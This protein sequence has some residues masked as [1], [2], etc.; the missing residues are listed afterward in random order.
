MLERQLADLLSAIQMLVSGNLPPMLV[1]REMLL[2]LLETIQE[3]LDR[4]HSQYQVI[5]KDISWYYRRATYVYLRTESELII[6]L[7]IPL[8][9]FRNP[10]FVYA[11]KTYPMVLPEEQNNVMRLDDIAFGIAVDQSSKFYYTLTETE[12]LDIG[13]HHHSLTKKI[14]TEFDNTSCIMNIYLDKRE[15]IDKFCKYSIHVNS[16][17]SEIYHIQDA[18]IFLFNIPHY[19]LVCQNGSF[20]IPGCTACLVQLKPHCIFR[21]KS[22]YIPASMNSTNS[23]LESTRHILNSPLIM[24]FFQQQS[25][26]FLTGNT[27]FDSPPKVIIPKFEYFNQSLSK[28]FAADD[29]IKLDL[30]KAVDAVKRDQIIVQSLSESVVLGDTPINNSLWDTSFGISITIGL[31]AVAALAVNS[32]YLMFRLRALTVSLMLLQVRLPKIDGQSYDPGLVFDY[33][34]TSPTKVNDTSNQLSLHTYIIQ[35]SNEHWPYAVLAIIF[36]LLFTF[37]AYRLYKHIL[38]AYSCDNYCTI[39]IE[40]MLGRQTLSINVLTLDGRPDDYTLSNVDTISDFRLHGIYRAK[41]SFKSTIT[42]IND[43]IQQTIGFPDS[44]SINLIQPF[45]PFIAPIEL[46]DLALTT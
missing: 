1:T 41:L 35:K 43:T 13:I 11:I 29:K 16:L 46:R 26:E 33:F 25:R 2:T 32:L 6:T 12:L 39:C 19:T 42:I 7:Q 18:Q 27:F 36:T 44:T 15:N 5:Y 23:V 38:T 14:F 10:F 20:V 4:D 40:F 21:F 37:V 34:Q 9:T 17:Q 24:K 22:W 45:T 8:T 28:S 30:Q 3:S 31:I